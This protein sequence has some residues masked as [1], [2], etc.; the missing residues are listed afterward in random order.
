MTSNVADGSD[1]Q[2][3]YDICVLSVEA[4]L[5]F[6][7]KLVGAVTKMVLLSRL[8]RGTTDYESYV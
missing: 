5:Q 1:E 8:E 4:P 2:L 3:V 7:Y 6:L